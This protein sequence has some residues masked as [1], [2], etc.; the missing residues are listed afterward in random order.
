MSSPRSSL[1]RGGRALHPSDHPC[2]GSNVERLVLACVGLHRSDDLVGCHAWGHGSELHPWLA[3]GGDARGLLVGPGQDDEPQRSRE[4]RYPGLLALIGRHGERD[5]GIERL[6][7]VGRASVE[8]QVAGEGKRFGGCRR[9]NC[10]SDRNR[11][12]GRGRDHLGGGWSTI[13]HRSRA[14]SPP[15]LP[16]LVAITTATAVTSVVN[17]RLDIGLPLL[18]GPPRTRRLLHQSPRRPK[19]RTNPEIPPNSAA[20]QLVD[21]SEI[22]GQD[23][24]A[25]EIRPEVVTGQDSP[26]SRPG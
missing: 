22:V 1:S 16:Q 3:V 4:Q 26:S 15:S 11:G 19:G 12:L 7:S 23:G 25:V 13:G 17:V 8:H 5:L 6:G 14:P 18:N 9:W 20:D 24:G 2:L 10:G 21:G